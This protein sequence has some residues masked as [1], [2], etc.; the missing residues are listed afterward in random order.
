[1]S[2]ANR[3]LCVF[4]FILALVMF[5]DCSSKKEE[6]KKASI[7][8]CVEAVLQGNLIQNCDKF[9]SMG[10]LVGP[11]ACMCN[12]IR[13][14]NLVG[15]CEK[16]FNKMIEVCGSLKDDPWYTVCV[17]ETTGEWTTK[18]SDDIYYRCLGNK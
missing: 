15:L 9:E 13:G 11:E 4:S 18:Y 12:G 7:E 16:V 17:Y 6:F 2:L 3:Y 10:A 14:N 8:K 1:M 5:T